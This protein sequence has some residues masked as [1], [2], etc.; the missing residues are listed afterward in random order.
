M[1]EILPFEFKDSRFV[2]ID[3]IRKSI[4]NNYENVV[5]LVKE[6]IHYYNYGNRSVDGTHCKY[7]SNAGNMCAVGRC[8]TE[9][10]LKDFHD[11]E[12]GTVF[13]ITNLPAIITDKYTSFDSMLQEKYQGIHEQVWSFMQGL[14][15]ED[16]NWDY[17]GLSS[18]G[19]QE[20]LN[21]LGTKIHKDVFGK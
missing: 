6:T 11:H 3:E 9:E 10:A 15:D 2:P 14:H 4:E 8:L 12:V 17:N 1:K 7:Q 19:E 5:S 16:E 21:A 18:N 20:I 13:A